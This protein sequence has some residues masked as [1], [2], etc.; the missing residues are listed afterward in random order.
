LAT[1]AQAL[2]KVWN[3]SEE[4][5]EKIFWKVVKK[6]RKRRR[7]FF[8]ALGIFFEVLFDFLFFLVERLKEKV[9][10]SKSKVQIL[11]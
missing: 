4:S 6:L 7:N 2:Q 9:Q 5:F 10:K 1:T 3:F 8:E 11:Y